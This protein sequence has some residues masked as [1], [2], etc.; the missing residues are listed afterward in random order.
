VATTHLSFVPG[1]NVRQLRAALAA[2][3]RL[4]APRVLLGDLN[5]PG[6]L[7]RAVV[8][9]TGWRPLASVAT[10]PVERP[11]IQFDHVL[12]HRWEGRAAAVETHALPVSDHRALVVELEHGSG[13][14]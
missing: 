10:Y 5:L 9:G 4:P 12:G 6:W 7:V 14:R 13:R 2:V 8:V 11:R 1:W 3:A